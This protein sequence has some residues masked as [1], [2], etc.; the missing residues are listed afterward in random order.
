MHMR[1]GPFVEE[2]ENRKEAAIMWILLVGFVV[3]ASMVCLRVIA[4]M[5]SSE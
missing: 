4:K 2:S 3:V 1:D 5:F